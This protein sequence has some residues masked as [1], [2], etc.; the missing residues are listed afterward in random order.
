MK[1]LKTRFNQTNP[2]KIKQNPNQTKLNFTK[3]GTTQL[4][5]VFQYYQLQTNLTIY[6]CL[7]GSMKEIETDQTYEDGS[8]LFGTP[9]CWFS[10]NK[11]GRNYR[12]K[13]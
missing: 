5:L 2:N 6:E 13:N 7:E 8:S 4:Q 1:S 3:L 11:E 10:S 12:V 9:I